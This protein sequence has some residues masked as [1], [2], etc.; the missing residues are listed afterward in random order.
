MGKA[1][2]EGLAEHGARVMLS[3]RMLD[4]C[5]AAADEIKAKC[6]ERLGEEVGATIYDSASMNTDALRDFLQE[7]LARFAVTRS[8][9]S[10]A[11]PL[12]RTASGKI[13]KHQLRD[14]AIAAMANSAGVGEPLHG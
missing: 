1:M 6:G 10:S 3:S 4:Q 12:A 13:F 2:A 14:E 8:I 9:Q 7:H 5:E 11:V